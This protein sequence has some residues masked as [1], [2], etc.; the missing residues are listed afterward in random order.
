MIPMRDGV[1]LH[2][3]IL[4]PEGRA[5]CP[6]PA[7]A[8]ALRRQR[9]DQPRRQRASGPDAAG[10][11]QCH[12]RDRGGRLHPRGAG[13]A[14]QIRLGGRL[15]D[16]PAAARPAESHAGGPRHGHLRH[17]R[18]AGEEHPGEQRQ[19]RHPGHLLRRVS[20]ADGAGES[21]SG[22]E[23]VRAHEPD[24]GWLD[25]RRLVSQRRVPPA[26]H[27]ATST[28][29]R[30]RATIGRQVVDR[31]TSTTTT[32]YMEAGS[33]GELGTRHGME[34]I[35]F[36]RKIAGASQLRRFLA[37]TRRWTGCWPRSR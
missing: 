28:N 25:G 12:R 22:A 31:V 14:R 20:A 8:H 27:A 3:V 34:Q 11:R 2:T 6:H 24:G 1:K 33:A 21:A 26:E 15:R 13:C 37:A 5:R 17:H 29:R 9:A 10:L 32:S 19:G 7:D 30:P 16:E 35:G 18:L 23:G 4:V 36:W